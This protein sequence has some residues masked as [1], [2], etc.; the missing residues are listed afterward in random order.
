MSALRSTGNYSISIFSVGRTGI[1]NLVTERAPDAVSRSH[2]ETDEVTQTPICARITEVL[3]GRQ[4]NPL[5]DY[6]FELTL[7]LCLS[8]ALKGG[9]LA[10]LAN[11]CS[12]VILEFCLLLEG[13]SI[14]D[15]MIN[16]AIF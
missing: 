3:N 5:G 2:S 9:I 11:E 4:T 16:D 6:H 10:E 14:H 1:G 13:C 7:F 8:V 15:V 12:R